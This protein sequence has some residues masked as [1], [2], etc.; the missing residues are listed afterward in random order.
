[1]LGFIYFKIICV[2]SNVM[3]TS[4]YNYKNDKIY[5]S[6]SSYIVYCKVKSIRSQ[7]HKHENI[8]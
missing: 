5:T 6:Q 1:M 2:L 7:V 3:Y 4:Q 8:K